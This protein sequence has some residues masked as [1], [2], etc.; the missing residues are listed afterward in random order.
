[1]ATLR[2][3]IIKISA[4]SSSFQSEIARAS[5]MG[6]DYYRSMEQGGR[7]A[8]AAARES[9]R[10][11]QELNEQLVTTRETALE[12]TG[13]FAG[14][15][16]T[17]HLIELAD[18]WNAVNARLKQ[19][20]QSTSEF[21]TVQK[22]L[23][24]ISQRT[25]TA[26][27]DN[28]DLY[29][30][31]AAS[32]REFG[33][34]AQDV[35]KVTEAVSTGLK[36]SSASTEES[37]SV[38]TQFSQA[39]AQG[40]LRGEEFNAVNEAGDRVIR[41][42]AAGMGVARKDLKAMAD[43]GQLTIDKVVPALTSQLGKLQSEFASLPASVAGSV[44]KVQNAF[45][46]W[47]GEA[48]TTSGATA[49][50]SGALEGVAKNIDTVATV[51][52]ALVA[53]G[54]ARFFGGMAS[55]AL[56][57]SAG[58]ITAY[59]NE[60]ALT[61]AQIHGTQISTARA[62][63]AVYRAQQAL[64]AA[65][66]TTAQ[67][68]AERRLA[69][70][71]LAVTRNAAARTAAQERLNSMTSLGSRLTSSALGLVGGIPGL[72]MLGAGAWY[73][74]YQRQEQARESARAYMNTLEDVKKAAPGMALPEV[75]D[76]ETKTRSSLNEQ[77]RLVEEQM[78]KVN[79]L[80]NEVQGYQQ[81]MA[82]PGPSVSGFLINHLTNIEE[83]SAGLQQATA[84]LVVEQERLNQMQG[85]SQSIQQ[86]LEALEHRRIALIRQ[87]AAE[88]NA[89]Y[90]SLVMMNGQHT[91]F[92]RLLSLGNNLLA[93]RQNLQ[94]VPFRL[95]TAQLTDKQMD[96]LNRS[97]REKQLSSLSGLEKVRKQAEY[98]ADDAGLTNTPEYTE[99]R[100]KFISNTVEAWQKQENLSESLKAGK[101]ALSDQAKEE[102]S[103]TQVAEQ[104]SRKI[105]DL[106]VATEVQR[107]RAS[108]G[109]KAAD[110]YAA[111]H[112]NG[113]K[114]T[115]EQR[116]AIQAASTQL[117]IW[118]Q[119]ADEA[120]RKQREMT[121]SLKDLREAA[122]KY[123]DDAA[124]TSGTA[125]MGDRQRDRFNEQQQVERVFDKTDK[126]A[127]AMAA[128]SAALDALD[129]KYQATA[130]AEQ[131]W[132]SGASRGYQN[133]LSSTSDVAGTV[134]Q[135]ITTTMDSALD[136]MSAMLVGSQADWKSWGLSVLQMISKVALQM[137]IVNAMGSSGSS[138]GS[139]LGSV[140][141]SFGGAAAGAAGTA[142]S[143]GAMGM[144]TSF[145]AYDGGGFTGAGGKFDPAG[146]VHK[147]EFVFTKEATDRIGVSNL[148]SLMKGYA[149]GGVVDGAAGISAY[150]SGVDNASGKGSTIIHVDA[151]VSIVQGEG[152]G[153]SSASSTSSAATQ[154]KSIVQTTITE[155]LRKEISPGGILYR[156]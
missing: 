64:V 78:A 147:G 138:W 58:I 76:S 99:A 38:I 123:S 140:A 98:S 143:T 42:L 11:I 53:V 105:A 130:A 141:S 139:I 27:G 33:Y 111:S 10:A 52:G 57:A 1:M 115:D 151:P 90:Q 77:N 152:S 4:N 73:T 97:E 32:M 116:K 22:S 133:W 20:S 91:E 83:V 29:A 12:M 85:K 137:A 37:S 135:G 102:R 70:A 49:S 86:V 51:A 124:L 61:Q 56:S 113:A 150:S 108:Q 41:A 153:D 14:A 109:E 114:W 80:K 31:S 81:I 120:V 155:R 8:A 6:T 44:T 156:S 60:V 67:E 16:A 63:A 107:I 136:N 46:Q 93:S 142:T 119:K 24:E 2:E 23:M 35:L 121:E 84:D 40:V 47:V 39:L 88:Q 7:K 19:A 9:Q 59:K 55:G 18:N 117:A 48:N 106:S 72:V 34:S 126:G 125:G 36:L 96:A 103:A 66:G 100:Q 75:S 28:A 17:G 149:N 25:G 30:R 134:S 13:V 74:M 69:A 122:R 127:E 128:R 94:N 45:E 71:Q 82:N 15:F 87:Q 62:R 43:Q 54:A 146:I 92:N 118:S 3:L 154:L 132:L 129:K 50:L 144:S 112:E 68:A 95:P 131:D 110:L 148:Y 5:R 104:Y 101:K 79:K 145:S 65:R 89:S 21:S 26:F